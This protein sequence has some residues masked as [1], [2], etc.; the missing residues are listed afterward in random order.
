MRLLAW[1]NDF[2]KRKTFKK[3]ISLKIHGTQQDGEI[4]AYQKMR[5]MK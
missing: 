5:I 4:D 1:R 3:D 2:Q